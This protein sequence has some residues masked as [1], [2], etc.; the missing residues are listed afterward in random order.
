MTGDHDFLS[1][2]NKGDGSVEVARDCVIEKSDVVRCLIGS[3]TSPRT[4]VDA[5]TILGCRLGTDLL[6]RSI[7]CLDAIGKAKDHSGASVKDRLVRSNHRVSCDNDLIE[8]CL[9]VILSRLS[10][11]YTY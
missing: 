8:G 6:K 10:T 2:D 11:I 7:E 4:G 5:I 3:I 1:S 9:P